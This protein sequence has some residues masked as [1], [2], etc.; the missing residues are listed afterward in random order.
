MKILKYKLLTL[1]L[2]GILVIILISFGLA[3]T[4]D[5]TK[6]SQSPTK[7]NFEANVG[8]VIDDKEFEITKKESPKVSSTKPNPTVVPAPTNTP[9]TYLVTKVVDGD[10]LSINKDGKEVTIRLIGLDTPETVHPS[11]PVECFG[12]EASNKAKQYLSGKKVTIEL[13]PTQGELDKYGRLLAYVYL[14]DGTLFNKLMIAEGYGHEYTYGT[15]YK[16]QDDFNKAEDQARINKKGL[17]ADGVCENTTTSTPATSPTPAPTTGGPYV[18]NSNKYNC[19]SFKTHNE[20]QNVYLSCGG[21]K[22]DIHRLDSDGDGVACES[23][24]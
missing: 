19:T 7:P 15:P 5:S 18:C 24:P 6:T 14:Q 22:T 2:L 1:V 20:A 11:K 3:N 13:D 8:G 9:K 10:T 23:L 16:Y 21:P 17:W 4:T 12:I